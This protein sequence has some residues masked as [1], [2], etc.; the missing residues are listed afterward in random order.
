MTAMPGARPLHW[1]L[2]AGVMVVSA[3]VV[4]LAFN[5]VPHT[6][7]DN[8][9]Y[10]SLA[11]DLITNGAYTDVFDPEGQPHTKYPPVFPMILAA[12]I[13]MG[14]RTWVALKMTAAVATVAAVGLTFLWA[15][16]ALGPVRGFAV[17]LLLSVSAAVVYYSHWILSDPLFLALTMAALYALSRADED[18]AGAGWLVAGVVAA[19]LAYFTRS[20]GLPLVVAVLAWLGFR[21]RWR[22]LAA[23]ATPFAPLAL[24]W[25][26]RGRGVGVGSY[27]SEFWMVDPYQPALGTI[28]VVGLIPRAFSNLSSYALDHG[29][30]GV[31]GQEASGLAVIGVALTLAAIVGWGV[32]VRERLGPAELFFPLYAGLILLW[33]EVW[34][35]DR[36]VLPLYPFVFYYGAVTLHEITSWLPSAAEGFAIAAVSLAL[37]VPAARNLQVVSSESSACARL[38]EENGVWACYGPQV[39]HFVEAATWAGQALPAGSA[40]LSRKPRHFYLLSGVPSRTFPFEEDADAHLSLADRLGARYVLLDRW[41]GQATRFVG[42]AITAAPGAFCFVRGFGQPASGGAQMLGVRP[43]GERGGGGS[44]TEVRIGACP[45]DYIHD[46]ASGASYAP[47]SSGRI[48]LLDRLNS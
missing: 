27:A 25:W 29:P 31:V 34:G 16:R 23:S 19:G 4:A 3:I 36:F 11:Y 33:P 46:A 17:A 40:V 22:A 5:P 37:L 9:G 18:D 21:R 1:A 45:S 48:P 35:G 38:A 2:L 43:P 6:G 15:E 30:A 44:E 12:L 28:G 39:A 7:G 26:W 8:A 24:A 14:A 10:V 32:R 20:A 42:A 41:D 13:W 47:S